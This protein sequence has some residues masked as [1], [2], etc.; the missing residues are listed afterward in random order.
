[1]PGR[2]A[3]RGAAVV[4]TITAAVGK[5]RLQ[6][7]QIGLAEQRPSPV[8]SRPISRAGR[9]ITMIRAATDA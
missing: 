8:G 6:R 3:Y 1:V 4:D 5:A 2:D 9:R 7:Q